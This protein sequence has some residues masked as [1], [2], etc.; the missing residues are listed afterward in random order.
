[1]DLGCGSGYLT[2]PIAKMNQDA[3]VI[4]LDIVTNTLK[5]NEERAEA[6]RG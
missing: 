6:D 1:M 3:Q 2:F 5:Q 4:G